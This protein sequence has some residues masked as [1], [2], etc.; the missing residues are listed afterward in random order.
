MEIQQSFIFEEITI[1]HEAGVQYGKP[2]WDFACQLNTEN[3][4]TLDYTKSFNAFKLWSS[5]QKFPLLSTVYFPDGVYPVDLFKVHQDN[6]KQFGVDISHYAYIGNNSSTMEE[7]FPTVTTDCPFDEELPVP[8]PDGNNHTN[9]DT[10]L[11]TKGI[12]LE[13]IIN[14]QLIKPSTLESLNIIQNS[15]AVM[16]KFMYN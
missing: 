13:S 2:V 7:R 5:T 11:K 4:D 6:N 16:P 10:L 8:K 9:L 3:S 12:Q 1:F 14:R 15:Q